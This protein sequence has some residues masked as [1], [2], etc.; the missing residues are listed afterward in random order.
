VTTYDR[1]T[2][3]SSGVL[4]GVTDAGEAKYD[5]RVGILTP[6]RVAV[7]TNVPSKNGLLT[8]DGVATLDGD[9]VLLTAQTDATQNGPW[10]VGGAGWSR[11]SEFPVG[12]TVRGRI[13]LVAEGTNVGIWE[14]V[15]YT[16][17]TIGT[18]IQTWKPAFT[19]TSTTTTGGGTGGTTTGGGTTTTTG[20]TSTFNVTRIPL[21]ASYIYTSG[22]IA[23]S[24]YVQLDITATGDQSF[25]I[26]INGGTDGVTFATNLGTVSSTAGGTGQIANKSVALNSTTVPYIQVVV[27]NNS[28]AQSKFT[29]DGSLR[30]VATGGTSSG[31]STAL[32]G[33]TD[34][35]ITSP[36][37][38]D[39][40][41]YN[42]G[43]GKWTNVPGNETLIDA[44]GDILVG[45]AD[46][47]LSKLAAGSGFLK[48]D[49]SGNI[50]WSS[51]GAGITADG[52]GHIASTYL[53]NQSVYFLRRTGAIGETF[54]RLGTGVGGNVGCISGRV[55]ATSIV[56]YAGQTIT[57]ITFMTSVAIVTP[58]NQWFCLYNSSLGKVAVTSDDTTTAWA[59]NTEKTLTLSSPYS[60][61]A[62]GLFYLGCMVAAATP[63]T[64]M[65]ITESSPAM[66]LSPIP[67]FN[68]NA[69]TGLTTPSTA[70]T[71]LTAS[72]GYGQAYAWVS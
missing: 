61:S 28:A 31:G 58:T 52:N 23:T 17:I 29:V 65:G 42:S 60:V 50:T 54:S 8:L 4:G 30:T 16:P 49:G 64:L 57:N 33:D 26:Q 71:T 40:L 27:T 10:I 37:D 24:G 41:R 72:V 35:A 34:V 18:T 11:P 39:A 55:A 44:K 22:P 46:N 68:D 69:H 14:M 62:D 7:T 51:A 59:A 25:S 9:Q 2:S 56:L 3:V 6:C 32:A 1:K 21:A 47:T 15:S 36:A 45:S 63:P 5:L 67:S 43:T 38:K 13:T 20:T 66:L 70:P 53:P 12:G 48:Q 19:G